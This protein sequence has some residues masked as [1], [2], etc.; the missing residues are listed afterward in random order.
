MADKDF[1]VKKGLVVNNNIGIGTKTPA[2]S[3]DISGKTDA[4][5]MPQGTT[6]Q[7][8][9]GA[10]GMF[11][12]N[13]TIG[14]FEG[15]STVLGGWS[16]VSLVGSSVDAQFLASLPASYYLDANN[17]TGT[18]KGENFVDSSHGQRTGG[19]LHAV[20]NTTANGFQSSTDKVAFDL[21]PAGPAIQATRGTLNNLSNLNTFLTAGIWTCD[22]PGDANVSRNFPAT[23]SGG[24]L[25]VRPNAAG[26]QI[27]HT[28]LQ[29]D[30]VNNNLVIWKRF[31]VDSGTNWT[32]WN[33]AWDNVTLTDA[34]LLAQIKNVDGVG[35][36]LDADL[37]DGQDG[38]FYQN[39]NNV[40][41]GTLPN[42]R[43]A[44]D[45]TGVANVTGT[46]VATFAGFLA[47]N[48]SAAAPSITF[49]N[50]PNTGIF[51]S[52]ADMI[53]FTTNGA[54]KMT[55]NSGGNLSV[56][57]AVSSATLSTTGA[58]TFG[59][60]VGVTG[61]ITATGTITGTFDT[62]YAANNVTDG[63]MAGRAYPRRSDGTSINL[64]WNGLGGQPS[65]L[66]GG[67]DGVNFNVYNPSNFNVYSVG[68]WTQPEIS[69]QIESRANAW[70]S[71]HVANAVTAT[72]M[73][74]LVSVLM[75]M[76]GDE[77]GTDI[78]FSGYVITRLYKGLPFRVTI[79]GRQ[80]QQYR[81]NFGW[82]AAFPF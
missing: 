53:G 28:F 16:Q 35:S 71:A 74:G 11:R 21:I 55:L 42:A 22:T 40:I 20:A 25:Q 6:G 69:A 54:V 13:T 44:G 70:G 82:V 4:V 49:G 79:E 9:A 46:G 31:S 67:N 43:L 52:A 39:A 63:T 51:S 29:R 26:T 72:R 57:G 59:G 68:G 77:Q 75:N 34:I 58:A 5:I 41:S 27:A 19:N 1:E 17:T 56:T 24:V 60:A 36:G 81:A 45:Y 62:R 38:A 2:A 33:R 47:A 61:N 18:I 12:F 15:Y 7:R 10:N 65:Y 73:A 23:G 76:G 8:P 64:I 32:A 37:L 78:N 66:I 30:T 14:E 3:L 50:D 80:P 48:G